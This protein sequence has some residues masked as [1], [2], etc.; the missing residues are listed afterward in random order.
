MKIR[1]SIS[2][3][4]LI[5]TI[6]AAAPAIGAIYTWVDAK[7]YTHFAD[8]IVPSEKV[9]LVGGRNKG[10][11][12]KKGSHQK[13]ND[14]T[15]SRN[16]ERPD[17]VQ[18]SRYLKV[19]A[20]HFVLRVER[21]AMYK[22]RYEANSLLPSDAVLMVRFENP[23]DPTEPFVDRA[24]KIESRQV[25]RSESPMFSSLACD[26]Y[27]IEVEIYSNEERSELLEVFQ[28]SIRSSIDIEQ[29]QTKAQWVSAIL[30]GNC[31]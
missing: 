6:L 15:K 16:R 14:S 7:G 17:A 4:F 12:S 26:E 3:A 27:A 2:C 1:P 10:Y 24:Q 9:S 29:P 21:T 23:T 5:G 31:R 19:L 20:S 25:Y 8:K 11:V 30:E 22:V 28:H 13:Q 18:Q